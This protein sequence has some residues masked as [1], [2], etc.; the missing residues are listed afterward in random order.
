M[1]DNSPTVESTHGIQI[2]HSNRDYRDNVI[3]LSYPQ[4]TASYD[5]YD[6]TIESVVRDLGTDKEEAA[7]NQLGE[8]EIFVEDD[9]LNKFNI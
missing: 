6:A 3:N 7:I 8:H 2:Y 5:H 1:I 9:V 4:A